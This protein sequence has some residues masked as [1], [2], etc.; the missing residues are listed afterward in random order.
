MYVVVGV[1]TVVIFT[2]LVVMLIMIVSR[3]LRRRNQSSCAADEDTF[4]KDNDLVRFSSVDLNINDQD[5]LPQ[6]ISNRINPYAELT[7]SSTYNSND[8][9][10]ISNEN[11]Y[12]QVVS[13]STAVDTRRYVIQNTDASTNRYEAL[14]TT[15]DN[16]EPVVVSNSGSNLE[17]CTAPDLGLD[18][19]AIYAKPLPR[20]DRGSKPRTKRTREDGDGDSDPSEDSDS[21]NSYLE[22]DLDSALKKG[23]PTLPKPFLTLDITQNLCYEGSFR[24]PDLVSETKRIRNCTQV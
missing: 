14:K 9:L 4:S 18:P 12:Q 7:V 24:S 6:Y 16:P 11:L 23:P 15:R 5:Q 10:F 3:K 21:R 1:V 2:F 17:Y 19:T 13:T 8:Q 20:R 22:T